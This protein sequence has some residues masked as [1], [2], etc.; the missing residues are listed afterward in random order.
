MFKFFKKFA[1][2]YQRFVYRYSQITVFLT[3]MLRDMQINVKTEFYIFTNDVTTI[4]RRLK[5][6]F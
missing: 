1:N 5:N 2:F 6:I 4:F 3:D